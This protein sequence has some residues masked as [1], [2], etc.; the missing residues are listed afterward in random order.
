MRLF[1]FLLALCLPAAVN[2]AQTS[3]NRVVAVSDQ[4]KLQITVPPDWFFAQTNQLNKP[5]LIQVRAPFNRFALEMTVYWDGFSTNSKP[6]EADFDHIITNVVNRQYV[7]ASVE[8]K[9]ELETLKG[10]GVRGRFARFTDIRWFAEKKPE[11]E[12][13]NVTTGMFR[14]DNLWG[15]FNLLTDDKNGPDFKEGFR[16]LQSLRK[17]P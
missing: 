4:G 3:T 11:G 7:P 8:K 15:H 9:V 6:T 16:I 1:V 10:P 12:Y 2:A 5:S 13:N 17:Q 14:C